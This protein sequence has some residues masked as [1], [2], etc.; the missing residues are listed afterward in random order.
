M[1]KDLNSFTG[2]CH[3]LFD[4]VLDIVVT[5]DCLLSI[6]QDERDLYLLISN[7]CGKVYALC[8]RFVY[9]ERWNLFN[10]DFNSEI[11]FYICFVWEICFEETEP[12]WIPHYGQLLDLIFLRHRLHFFQPKQ[13]AM[14]LF[15]QF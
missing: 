4:I 5:L 10:W 11:S 2:S 12:I 15:V 14:K 3:A 8:V 13:A 7:I 9:L 6:I 1:K